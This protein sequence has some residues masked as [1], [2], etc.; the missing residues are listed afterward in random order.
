MRNRTIVD[1]TFDAEEQSE[2]SASLSDGE[3]GSDLPGDQ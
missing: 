3:E 2:A 1:P